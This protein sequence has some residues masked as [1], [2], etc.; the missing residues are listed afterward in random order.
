MF[1][2]IKLMLGVAKWTQTAVSE[3]NMH[4]ASTDNPSIYKLSHNTYNPSRYQF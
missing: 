3:R 2:L 4:E 1:S